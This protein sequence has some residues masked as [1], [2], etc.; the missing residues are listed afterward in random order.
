LDITKTVKYLKRRFKTLNPE[1][2]AE[3]LDAVIV[4][5]TLPKNTRGFFQMSKRI[6]II[7]INEQLNDI[8][9]RNVL[10]HELAHA[11]LHRDMNRIFM[12]NHTL[13]VPDRYENQANLLAAYM[14]IEDN[15]AR[16][17][18]NYKFTYKQISRMTGIKEQFVKQ[19]I[20]DYVDMYMENNDF[21]Y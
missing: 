4:T 11:I 12:D 10:A 21:C 13:N 5:T 14:L 1:T 18:I 20:D 9:R 19:R 7:Y 8:E 6:I 17:F 16:E 3:K 2:I 15:D